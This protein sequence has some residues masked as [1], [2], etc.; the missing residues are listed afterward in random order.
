MIDRLKLREKL[1]HMAGNL[2]RRTTAEGGNCKGL[3]HKT[4]GTSLR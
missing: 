2:I 1:Y 4:C 3:V